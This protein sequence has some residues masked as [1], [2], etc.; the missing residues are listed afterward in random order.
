MSMTEF[1]GPGLS[2]S[3][4]HQI[5][6]LATTLDNRQLQWLSGFFAGIE[7][8]AGDW[9][10]HT[11]LVPTQQDAASSRRITILYG[12]E[13]GTAAPSRQVLPSGPGP[14]GSRPSCSTWPTTNCAA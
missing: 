8:K 14:R 5:K 10:T 1:R 4:W 3:Q 11:P 2:E 7:F 13:T 9:G 6:T 12:S